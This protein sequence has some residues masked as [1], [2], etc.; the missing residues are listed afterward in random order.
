[1]RFQE[2]TGEVPYCV[3]DVV[4]TNPSDGTSLA[5][6]L[7]LPDSRSQPSPAVLLIPG[8]GKQDRD[9]SVCGHRPFLVW[10]DTLTRSGVG[11]LRLDDRGVGGSSGD[12]DAATHATLLS[13][14][15]TALDF[16]TNHAHVDA[17]RL[18]V[19]G[20]SE[21]ALLA[22]AT[23]TV[24]AGVSLAVL[25]ACPGLPGERLLHAQAEAI[26][27]SAGACDDVIA[28]ERAMN[29]AV[30][31]LL[32]RDTADEEVRQLVTRTLREHLL[33]WPGL[34]YTATAA[35]ADAQLMAD[36]VLAPAF[37]A[38]LRSDVSRH[39][40]RIT[41]P[42]LVLIGEKDIQV[43]AHSNLA[44]IRAALDVAPCGQA[45]AELVP[46]VN[47]LLQ[48][49]V[50]GAIEEYEMLEQTISPRVLT[51]VGDWIARTWATEEEGA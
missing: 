29:T 1:M 21:G 32:Q 4:L 11:V 35:A 34:A 14:I 20:H 5:G 3:V 41:C 28:H 27:R 33:S 6:T 44:A 48:D 16:L 30:F 38:F 40:R 31:A 37:G 2:P 7:T 26:S 51:R 47:H 24:P 39:L 42:T 46:G 10:A 43:D 22:A 45:T 13:D 17:D 23:A 12:K 19:I 49:C 9:E 50:T 8:S 15:Q 18:G 36:V 25:L